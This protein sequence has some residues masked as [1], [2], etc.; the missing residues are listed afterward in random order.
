LL[1]KI[2]MSKFPGINSA[3]KLKNKAVPQNLTI[4]VNNLKKQLWMP[5]LCQPH[6]VKI[7]TILF[8]LFWINTFAV[9]KSTTFFVVRSH[10]F[11]TSSLLTFSH[12]YRSISCNHCLTLLKDS[13]DKDIQQQLK[14]SYVWYF[15][16][17]METAWNENTLWL[18]LIRKQERLWKVNA[19]H[20]RLFHNLLR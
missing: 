8:Y 1:Q 3:S 9:V 14:Y 4:N 2:S 7:K 15:W 16:L 13:C 12:A 11:P 6:I 18:D 10:L 19:N 20:L 5:Q 17:K